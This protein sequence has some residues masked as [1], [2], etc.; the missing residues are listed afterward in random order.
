MVGAFAG[1]LFSC[2]A[3]IVAV[4]VGCLVVESLAATRI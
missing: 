1:G 2:C 3:A 4:V